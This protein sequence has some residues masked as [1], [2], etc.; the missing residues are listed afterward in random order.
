M[1]V[2][3]LP[4]PRKNFEKLK[5]QILDETIEIDKQSLKESRSFVYEHSQQVRK[6]RTK[7]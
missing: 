6:F 3:Q 2:S 4:R 1:Q 5:N 7:G